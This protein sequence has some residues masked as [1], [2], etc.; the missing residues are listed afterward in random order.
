ML[1]VGRSWEV[2]SDYRYGFNGMENDD[3]TYGDN[4]AI[5]FGERIYDSRLGRWLSLDK[6]EHLYP[7]I[8]P[9]V[10][11]GSNP[12]NFIDADG[13]LIRD[14]NGNIVFV[15]LGKMEVKHDGAKGLTTIMTVGY[16]FANDG[17]K[18]EVLKN[19][20]P[21]KIGWNTDCHG[22]SFTDGVYWINNNQVPTL[23]AHDG[24][25]E[26]EYENRTEGDKVIYAD[27]NNN[28]ED[29]RTITK[30]INK[31]KGQ[32]GLEEADYITGIDEA[33][34]S[35]NKR[36]FRKNS[37]DV[38]YTDEQISDLNSSINAEGTISLE[39]TSSRT[40]AL[41]KNQ[42]SSEKYVKQ[43]YSKEKEEHDVAPSQGNDLH[44]PK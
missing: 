35:D 34:E 7:S 15:P 17:T 31:V 33:W 12:T 26:I 10:F 43:R 39:E 18:I 21:E 24:Y 20:E 41:P 11:C 13:N 6:F 3:N 9:Y 5:N 29:S 22:S 16:I 44:Y 27:K 25:L 30:D 4:N 28:V 23:L 42:K 8:S 2:A 32:G 38:V 1:L 37:T 40:S 19:D 14:K 36:I